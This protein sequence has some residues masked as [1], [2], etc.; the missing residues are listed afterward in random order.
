ML[1]GMF[2]N[3]GLLEALRKASGPPL[4]DF[5]KVSCVGALVSAMA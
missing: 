1:W 4:V 5:G 2:L 3:Y